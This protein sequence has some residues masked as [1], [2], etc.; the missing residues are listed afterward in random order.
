[1]INSKPKTTTAVWPLAGRAIWAAIAA[2]HVPALFSAWE[3]L[4]GSGWDAAQ[5][6][7]CIG[8]TLSVVLFSLKICDVPF[9]RLNANRRSLVA[10]CIAMALI[11]GDVMG[12]DLGPT[13]IPEC[14]VVVAL[15]VGAAALPQ[16][17]RLF[18]VVAQSS[19]A[20]IQEVS[21]LSRLSDSAWL[22][23]ITRH[24]WVLCPRPFSLRA[25]PA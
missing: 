10:S 16:C 15:G 12:L 20:T 11:H 14:T 17:R 5:L 8:L 19:R 6:G 21:P 9:L 22:D 23:G 25:P 4:A 18:E 24:R 2:A 13:V 7:G 3:R 1:M